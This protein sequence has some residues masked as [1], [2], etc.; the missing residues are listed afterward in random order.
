MQLQPKYIPH[1]TG[2]KKLGHLIK[3]IKNNS[4]LYLPHINSHIL[5]I[6]SYTKYNLNSLLSLDPPSIQL[7]LQH[8]YKA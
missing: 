2:L 5:S 4:K 1:C 3:N 7:W 8:A 6:N